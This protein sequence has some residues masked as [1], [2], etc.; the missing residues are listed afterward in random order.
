MKISHETLAKQ[1]A[2]LINL[3]MLALGLICGLVIFLAFN[4]PVSE[5]QVPKLGPAP[6]P[7][8]QEPQVNVQNTAKPKP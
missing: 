7:A 1:H 6:V 8:S 4:R 2:V 5:I 3:L